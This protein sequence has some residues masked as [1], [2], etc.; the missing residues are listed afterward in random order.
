MFSIPH[1]VRPFPAVARI[2]I[3][4]ACLAWLSLGANFL[5]GLGIGDFNAAAQSYRDAYQKQRTVEFDKGLTAEQK[6]TSRDELGRAGE[7]LRVPR[8]RMT[9]HFYLGV[10]SSLLVILVNSVSVTYF[11]G[12]SR[13]CKEVAETYDLPPELQARSTLLK[14]RTFPWALGGMLA[15]VVLVL[16]GGLSDP[17]IPLNQIQPGRSALMVQ[18]HYLAA[19]TTLAFIALMFSVQALR[20][21]ENNQAIE[22]ILTE[23]RRIRLAKG[24]PVSEDG[25]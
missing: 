20:M 1:S 6:Q 22:A 4:L 18:W 12:T 23:V 19:M 25:P 2:F 15:I 7:L 21:I 5:V 14:R 13:W 10:A 16:L 24:L 3:V 8:Q 17:S 11:I 9:L